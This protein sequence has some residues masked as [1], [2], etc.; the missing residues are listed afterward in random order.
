MLFDVVLYTSDSMK[1]KIFEIECAPVIGPINS[2][3]AL[4]FRIQAHAVALTCLD[5]KHVLVR[6]HICS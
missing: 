6:Y 2:D 5:M 1:A 4:K 3:S